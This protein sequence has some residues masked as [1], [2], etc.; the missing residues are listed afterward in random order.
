MDISEIQRIKNKV[1]TEGWPKM[2]NSLVIEGIHGLSNHQINFNFPI[3]GIV[4]EN[5]TCKSTVL[6]ALALAY[7]DNT[8]ES[9]LLPSK[10]FPDTSWETISNV[11]ITYQIKQGVNT[12]TK[13]ISKLTSRW[14]GLPERLENSVYYFDLNRIQPIESLIGS[15]KFLNKKIEEIKSRNLGTE[16]MEKLSSVMERDYSSGRYALTSASDS[17]EVG[18]LKLGFGEVSQ[19]HQGSGESNIFDFLATIENIPDYSL[20]I[21][22]EIESSLHPKAQRRLIRELLKLTRLKRLQIVISTHSPYV[23][24]ELPPESRILLTRTNEGIDVMYAPTV[25]LCLSRID[26]GLHPEIDIITEDEKSKI[27]LREIIRKISPP[28]IQRARF[29]SVGAAENVEKLS[30]LANGGKIPYSLLGF[31]DADQKPKCAM[32]LP[33]TYCPEKQIFLDIKEDKNS[34]EMLSI[35][36]G[37]S[38]ETLSQQIDNLFLNRNHREWVTQLS[39]QQG[40]E[41]DS[42]WTY[43]CSVWTRNCLQEEEAK[44]IIEEIN[45]RLDLGIRAA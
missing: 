27:L 7:T 3:C 29:L 12:V 6:K 45:K 19:F 39:T 30:Q 43:L 8:R 15:S 21:I 25:E 34:L 35:L 13:N 40:L 20:V 37:I 31:V 5:G 24:S 10:F 32:C 33:G 18:L 23:L 42:L 22:D 2:V 28:T 17:F 1:I 14:R 44:T 16:S 9:S 11:K 4:G 41:P 36:F 38:K 26:E